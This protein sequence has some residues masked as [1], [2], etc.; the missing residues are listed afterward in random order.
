MGNIISSIFK[1]QIA[2]EVQ[3]QAETLNRLTAKQMSEGVARNLITW[4]NYGNIVIDPVTYD[5]I[6]SGYNSVSAVYECVDIITKKA[7]ACPR[8]VYRIKDQKEYKKY[9]NFSA[10]DATAAKT[11]LAKAKALEEVSM[12]AI[13]KLLESPNPYNNGDDLIEM[14][15]GLYL[16]MGNSFL[17]G[18]SSNPQTNRKWSEI[19]AVPGMMKIKAGTWTDPIISYQITHGYQADPIPAHQIKH[20]KTFNPAYLS[21]PGNLFGMSPLRAYLYAMNVIKEGD[22]QANKQVKNGGKLGVLAPE[23]K[24]DYLG[25]SQADQIHSSLQSA[26]ASDDPL[27]RI[28]PFA[29]SMKWTEIGLSSSEMELLKTIDAKA[30][31]IYR[32]YH[33]PLQFRTQDTATYNN[34]PVANRQLVYNAV[35]PITRK[36]SKGLTEFICA[37]YNTKT[38]QYIIELDFTSL[39]E[40]ND[41]MKTVAEWLD[42]CDDLTPNEKREVKGWGRSAQPGMDEIYFN[43]NKVRL[44]DIMDGKVS[45]GGQNNQNQSNPTD[46]RTDM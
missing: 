38:D 31:D 32:A 45:Y 16:L 19:W 7:V 29:V 11:M 24:E 8:I 28:V 1:G 13:E 27:A 21:Q 5:Y 44:Q 4:L 17:Y 10:A 12:P 9:L 42:K 43:R 36:I 25:E 46:L 20:F 3:K 23:N 14:L 6:E 33:I 18:N 40:L 22:K 39:P 37:P 30:D 26:H 2:K 15:T 41:D 34:L 35:A